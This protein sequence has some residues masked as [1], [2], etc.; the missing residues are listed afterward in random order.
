MVP[1]PPAHAPCAPAASAALNQAL[2]LY[3]ESGN[4]LGR[5]NALKYLGSVQKL[6]GDC[7]SAIATLNQ[8]LSLYREVGSRRGQADT[9]EYL[10]LAHERSGH[11]QAA[12][13]ALTLAREL[14]RLSDHAEGG[15]S[16]RPYGSSP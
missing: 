14:R 11:A 8:A 7:P 10:S 6:S 1:D 2:G 3:Q 9:L 13:D 15:S 5:A 12:A 4:R 16:P